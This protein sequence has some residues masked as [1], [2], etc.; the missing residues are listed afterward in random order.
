MIFWKSFLVFVCVYAFFARSILNEP[1]HEPSWKGDYY[2][3][4][5]Y[6]EDNQ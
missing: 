2:T 5:D 4:A 1:K 6:M 3:L